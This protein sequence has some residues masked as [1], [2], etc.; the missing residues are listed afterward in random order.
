MR[1][2]RAVI[3]GIND[4]PGS[5]ADLHGCVNDAMDWQQVLRGAGYDTTVLL[6][7]DA[8]KAAVVAALRNVVTA[9]RFG[10]RVVF[11]YSGHG[12]WLPDRNGDEL[13]QRDEALV[14]HD[15]RSGGLLTD[16]EL[17]EI[18]SQRRF[19]VRGLILSDS[20]HSGTVTR[21]MM[22]PL[23]SDRAP[24][25]L[26]PVTFLSGL[27]LAAAERVQT[28]PPA[29]RPRSGTV[30][31]SGCA[32]DEVSYDVHDTRPH[33]AFTFAALQALRDNPRNLNA[34]YASI[35]RQLPS[36]AY[37]QT[38]QL[39]VRNYQRWWRPLLL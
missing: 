27:D 2:R 17:H 8:T 31:I 26:P 25:F 15:Y 35:R 34:W 9:S 33:G 18:F 28:M 11:T 3:V 20:C 7:G 16:D 12:T 1:A 24:R 22:D 6:D 21:A 30:L 10:D 37:P 39:E 38:P 4:Y 23:G 14:C 5:N 13:D 36:E 19:G 29:G 32:D